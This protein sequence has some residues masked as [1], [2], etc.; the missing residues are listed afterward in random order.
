MFSRLDTVVLRVRDL[1]AARAWYAEKLALDAIHHDAAEGLAVLGMSGGATLTL[2]QAQEVPPSATFP[3]LG[4]D[5][6]AA[7]RRHLEDR[8]VAVEP[9]V[10]APDVRYFGFRDPDGNR[11]EVCEVVQG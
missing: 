5:D 9:L 10:E 4:V 6:A 7:A 11:L 8:G 1:E 2:W 3:I